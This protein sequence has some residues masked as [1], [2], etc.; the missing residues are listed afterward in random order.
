MNIH[1]GKIISRGKES[2]RDHFV[3]HHFAAGRA[4][5]AGDLESAAIDNAELGSILRIDDDKP[6]RSQ[7]VVGCRI[8]GRGAELEGA[9]A[10]QQL[11]L[12]SCR[13]RQFRRCCQQAFLC[14]RIGLFPAEVALIKILTD[15]G[16][17]A[18][19]IHHLL[20]DGA[21][22]RFRF[23]CQARKE[24]AQNGEVGARFSRRSHGD[25]QSVDSLVK[26]GDAAAFFSGGCARQNNR[27][28]AGQITGQN[29]LNHQG[30]ELLQCFT[31]ATAFGETDQRVGAGEEK[32]ANGAL[33][34]SGQNS[35]GVGAAL[36]QCGMP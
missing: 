2:D 21:F 32:S 25:S 29:V 5:R 22:T 28:H 18:A 9:L 26:C 3:N 35:C 14:R 17:T 11:Q 8:S 27:C 13:G 12:C 7:F 23:A 34:D 20:T 24:V 10:D 16:I 33:F 30:V 1:I 36:R 6:C 15:I 31:P 19:E 4:G